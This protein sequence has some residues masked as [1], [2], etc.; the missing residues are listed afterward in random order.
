MGGMSVVAWAGAPRHPL[1]RVEPERQ[2]GPRPF[3]AQ[4]VADCPPRVRAAFGVTL[5]K[6]DLADCLPSLVVPTAVVVGSEDVLTPPRQAEIIARAV[7]AADLV[8]LPARGHM[9]PVKG[10]K[11]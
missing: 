9:V 11:T 2:A 7:V 10:T 1:R 4:M 6:L 3:C 5:A 8:K